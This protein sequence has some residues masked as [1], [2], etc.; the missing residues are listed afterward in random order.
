MIWAA[1]VGGMAGAMLRYGL[2]KII[3]RKA[4]AAGSSF[5]WGTWVI[6]ISGSLLLGI[7]YVLT[8][9]GILLPLWWAVLGIGFCGAYT[10]FST[11]GY[12]TMQLIREHLRIQAALYVM[13]SIIMGVAAAFAGMW[14]TSF[15]VI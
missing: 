1:G 7:L 15:I 9:E 10:T 13:S 4:A 8:G 12:E 3:S 11:F 14:F 2:G 5:P 6:N